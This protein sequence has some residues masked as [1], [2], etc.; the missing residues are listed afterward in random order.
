MKTNYLI[1]DKRNSAVLNTDIEGY[2]S[3]MNDVKNNRRLQQTMEQ[4]KSLD[5]D[6]KEIKEM[7]K[8]LLNGH[9]NG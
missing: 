4:V 9:N 7:L 3:Y 5:S 2:K 6:V 8:L 1:R